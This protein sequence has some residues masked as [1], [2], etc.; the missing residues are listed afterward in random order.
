MPRRKPRKS[1]KD[2]GGRPSSYRPE[3][4]AMARSLCLLGYRD[5]D[6][7][8]HFGVAE[9]TLGEWK[10]R[11][12]DFIQALTDGKV[13]ADA[14]VVNSLYSNTQDRYVDE[15]VPIKLK[16]V[17]VENGIRKEL[18][19]VEVVTVKKFVRADTTSMIYWLKCRQPANWRDTHHHEHTGAEGGPL[20][21]SITH[22][23]IDPGA[24]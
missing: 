21:I 3:Y 18:E 16:A 19:R 6:L 2:K 23:I 9:S 4:G 5:T 10:K 22:K 20:E 11:H 24:S 14:R 1:T 17:V 7:A 13:H 8:E 15:Q 12:P